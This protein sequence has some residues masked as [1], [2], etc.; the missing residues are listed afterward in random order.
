MTSETPD[1]LYHYT[2]V[3][4]LAL[5]LRSKRIRFSPL[6]ALDDPQEQRL[7]SAKNLAKCV[8]VSSWTDSEKELYA[9]WREYTPPR[10]GVRIGLLANP[11]AFHENMPDELEKAMGIPCFDEAGE[12]GCYKTRVKLA[13]LC[14][15]G[16][17]L[18][19]NDPKSAILY[20]VKYSDTVDE[21]FPSLLSVEPDGNVRIETGVCGTVKNTY[22]EHQSEWRY[23]LTVIPIDIL[24]C[25]DDMRREAAIARIQAFLMDQIDVDM[26]PYY[27]LDLDDSALSGIEIVL[28]P[29]ISP[30]NRLIVQLLLDTY[31]PGHVAQDSDIELS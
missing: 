20:Q 13:D 26:P 7:R 8:F 14:G 24:D 19:E 3:E 15:S 6:T 23:K 29:D 16:F 18:S 17:L 9:M 22:W 27:E 1:M 4:S 2:S 10:A 25:L 5:I 11:F 28:S 12:T 30:G 21:L 31:I